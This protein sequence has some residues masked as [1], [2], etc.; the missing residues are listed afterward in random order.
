MVSL[1]ASLAVAL[2]TLGVN[3]PTAKPSSLPCAQHTAI[4]PPPPSSLNFLLM[5]EL[6]AS[7]VSLIKV[8]PGVFN[9]VHDGAPL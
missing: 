2:C 3:W 7:T 5:Q 6:Y 4:A 9:Q 1:Q 8:V